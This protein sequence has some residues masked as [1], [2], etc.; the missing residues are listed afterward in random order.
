MNGP[1]PLL[2]KTIVDA[3]V[4]VGVGLAV[5][6]KDGDVELCGVTDGDAVVVGSN[7]QNLWMVLGGVT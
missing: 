1:T 4:A 2:D 5:V 3:F 7:D 6:T